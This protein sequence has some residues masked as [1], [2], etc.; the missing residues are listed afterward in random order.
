VA[1]GGRGAL[2]DVKIKARKTKK[3][4]EASFFCEVFLLSNKN[5]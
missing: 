4:A 1:L 2:I 5:N 3:E